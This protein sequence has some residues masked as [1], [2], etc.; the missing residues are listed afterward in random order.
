MPLPG[1]RKYKYPYEIGFFP[2]AQFYKVLAKK[3]DGTDEE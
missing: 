1:G 2:F 3:P